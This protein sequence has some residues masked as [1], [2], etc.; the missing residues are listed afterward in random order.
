M[1]TVISAAAGLLPLLPDIARASRID[2][3]P[4]VMAVLAVTAAITRIAAIPEVDAWLD[5]YLP[6]LSA[7][8]SD[9]SKEGDIDDYQ[10]RHRAD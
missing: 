3:I 2:T 6:W 8:P 7:D 10:G 1:R 9:D 5:K 4:A